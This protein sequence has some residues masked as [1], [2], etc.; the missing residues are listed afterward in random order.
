[1]GGRDWSGGLSQTPDWNWEQQEEGIDG[2]AGPA[3]E[4]E[5]SMEEQGIWGHCKFYR[6]SMSGGLDKIHL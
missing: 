5:Q 1:M 3:T 6:C 2:L 4:E